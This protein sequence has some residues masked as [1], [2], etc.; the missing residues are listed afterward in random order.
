MSARC[1]RLGAPLALLAAGLLACE[2]VV[3]N[4][5]AAAAL[6]FDGIAFPA[7][8][9]GDTLRNVAGIATPLSATVYD[10]RG[11]VIADAPVQFFS[12]DSGVTIDPAGYVIAQRARGTIRLVASVAGMQSQRRSVQITAAPDTVRSG[13]TNIT[14]AYNIPDAPPSVSPALTLTVQG[15]QGDSTSAPA[16]PGWLVRWRIVY[17]GDTIAPTDT[18]KVALWP[19]SASRHGLLDTTRSDGTASRRLR[20]YTNLLPVRPDSFIVIAEIRARG[21]QVPGSPV[22]Y[23]VNTR[24]PNIP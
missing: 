9:S 13:E 4:P 5:D 6:D 7:I 15:A 22:R 18:S 8:V 19:A 17:H 1:S 23:V 12:L 14:Y 24:P 16:V 20:V 3:T 10:G 21:V 2:G 11:T